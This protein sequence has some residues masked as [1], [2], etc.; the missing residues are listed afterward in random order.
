MKDYYHFKYKRF[1]DYLQ[2]LI[3]YSFLMK[4]YLTKK[5]FDDYKLSF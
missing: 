1:L 4:T 3:G 5:I 2:T